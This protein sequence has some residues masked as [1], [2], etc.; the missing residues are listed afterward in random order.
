MA[1]S[2]TPKASYSNDPALYIYTSLTAGSS[3]IVTATARMETILKANRIPFKAIDLATDEKARMLWGRRAGKDASGR[4]RKIPGL[5]QMG[6]VLG[7]L[8]EVE[9]WNEYGELK[10]HV[11]IVNAPGS[12]VLKPAL[13]PPASAPAKGAPAPVAKENVKPAPELAE[14]RETEETQ[15]PASAGPS[16]ISLAL[17]Q[18]GQEAAQKAKDNKKSTKPVDTLR[19]VGEAKASEEAPQEDGKKPVGDSLDGGEKKPTGAVLQDTESAATEGVPEE[20]KEDEQKPPGDSVEEGEK[21]SSTA[22]PPEATELKALEET[23]EDEKKTHEEPVGED[24]KKSPEAILKE[25]GLKAPE[26]T[27][28]AG[29]KDPEYPVMEHE[30]N[31]S[32]AIPEATELKAPEEAK[33]DEKKAPEEVTEGTRQ[34]TLEETSKV[35]EQKTVK[36]IPPPISIATPTSKTS[37]AKKLP[38]LETTDSF[39]SPSSTA[40]KGAAG[41]GHNPH[42]SIDRLDSIQSPTSSAFKPIDTFPTIML[43]RGFSALGVPPAETKKAEEVLSIPGEDDA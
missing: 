31:S 17:R 3:H 9:D 41:K 40:W 35:T 6:L 38:P 39:Q 7:D 30:K 27:K 42:K 11:K 34:K 18:A 12:L 14:K 4:Q 24:E 20:T 15:S 32:E 1:E 10:Q 5:V 22:K 13:K 29:K 37:P 33:E 26:E 19:G 36:A 8:V 21:K 23:K 43:H 25:T 2:A 16:P 28:E